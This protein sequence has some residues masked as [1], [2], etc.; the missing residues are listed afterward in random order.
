MDYQIS[1]EEVR[2]RLKNGDN[3]KIIDV[4]ED[5]E[6]VNGH[7]PGAI[8]IPLG[9]LGY[10]YQELDKQEE[11]LIVCRSGNR[12]EYATL[13]LLHQGFKKVKNIV[14]GMLDWTGKVVTEE[15]GI[16]YI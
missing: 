5:F 1:T 9:T 3:V 15:G 2:K 10:R 13:F 6:F 16:K 14:G 4:R 7:I 12:S 11:Y 8:L